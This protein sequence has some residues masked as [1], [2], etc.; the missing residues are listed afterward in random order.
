MKNIEFINFYAKM[1]QF[2]NADSRHQL[3]GVSNILIFEEIEKNVDYDLVPEPILLYQEKDFLT[4]E[5]GHFNKFTVVK[6]DRLPNKYYCITDINH[7]L[8]LNKLFMKTDREIQLD[9]IVK[10]YNDYDFLKKYTCYDTCIKM[11]MSS[12][13]W[14]EAR[15]VMYDMLGDDLLKYIK[16][17]LP[18]NF[19]YMKYI[20]NK[21]EKGDG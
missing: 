12:P 16:N 19:Y 20:K 6:H 13:K 14:Q 5:I 1:M 11:F 21:K 4:N 18:D 15:Q 9:C 8:I 10:E 2:N 17:Y 3:I 7:Y